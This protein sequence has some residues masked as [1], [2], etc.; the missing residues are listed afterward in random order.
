MNER[1][2]RKKLTERNMD[3]VDLSV[4]VFIKLAATGD[5]LGLGGATN[6]FL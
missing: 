3:H 2:P 5:E 4:I 1:V 6:Q